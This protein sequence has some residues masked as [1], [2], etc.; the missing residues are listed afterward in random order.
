MYILTDGK[1]YVMENPL[2]HGNY[3]QTT[4]SVKAKEFTYKQAK[5]L[6]QTKKKSLSW[7]KNFYLVNKVSAYLQ[8]PYLLWSIYACV[9]NFSI[10]FLNM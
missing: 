8:S 1:N 10:F 2:A 5:S 4:Y 3:I 6:L 9:L 7:I